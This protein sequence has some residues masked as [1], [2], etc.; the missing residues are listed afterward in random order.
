[1]GGRGALGGT[2]NALERQEAMAKGEATVIT[3]AVTLAT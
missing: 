3:V 2:N 1:M